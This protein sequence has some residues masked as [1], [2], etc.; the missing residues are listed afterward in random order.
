M[1]RRVGA[2]FIESN[3]ISINA[4]TS[5]IFDT[6]VALTDEAGETLVVCVAATE[7]FSSLVTT[8][9]VSVGAVVVNAAS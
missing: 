3:T 7:V 2:G 4:V 8:D 9:R 1:R 6:C 5:Q